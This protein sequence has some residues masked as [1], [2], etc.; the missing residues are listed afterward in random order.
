MFVDL[1]VSLFCIV[2]FSLIYLA[3]FLVHTQLGWLLSFW[4]LDPSLSW[5]GV[6]SISFPVQLGFLFFMCWVI[7][8]F[9]LDV[10]KITQGSRSCLDVKIID[11]SIFHNLLHWLDLGCD[12]ESTI[13]G[14]KF[15]CQCS[16]VC[17]C[18]VGASPNSQLE[19][20]AVSYRLIQ[21]SKI[22]ACWRGSI[23]YMWG[24]RWVQVFKKLYEV[25]FQASLS[26]ISPEIS[27]W[28]MLLF[29]SSRVLRLCYLSLHA[30]N[31]AGLWEG[32]QKQTNMQKL[33][34]PSCNLSSI[35]WRGHFL[36]LRAW[37]LQVP[38]ATGCACPDR[39][40]WSEEQDSGE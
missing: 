14:A 25:A 13:C 10:L 22:L 23:P 24:W 39:L 5:N 32:R 35:K 26:I 8:G 21:F 20:R 36:S 2:G 7:L 30:L 28:L 11:N 16:V 37:F 31:R 34:A 4:W 18:H 3:L 1:S 38:I 12:F 6:S 9:I 17:V 40:L 15:P 29:S 19:T 27:F 33:A